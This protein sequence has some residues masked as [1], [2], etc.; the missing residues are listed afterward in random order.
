MHP[1][2]LEHQ[3]TLTEYPW[4]GKDSPNRLE[5]AAIGRFVVD[6]NNPYGAPNNQAGMYSESA[7]NAALNLVSNSPLSSIMKLSY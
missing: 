6:H 4:D 7:N 1:L 3:E 5:E 2:S